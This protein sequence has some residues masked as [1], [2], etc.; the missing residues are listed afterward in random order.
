MTP[1]DIWLRQLDAPMKLGVWFENSAHMI[2]W[3]EPRK[4]LINLVEKVR[5]VAIAP[6]GQFPAVTRFAES[7]LTTS[8]T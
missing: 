5:P 8:K 1:T 4:F 3:E 6:I 2:P 7:S